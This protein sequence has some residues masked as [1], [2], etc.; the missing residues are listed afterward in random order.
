MAC[1]E[2]KEGEM[3]HRNIWR[4]RVTVNPLIM[5]L[6]RPPRKKVI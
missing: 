4:N 6:E 2:A 1:A 3:E 5:S